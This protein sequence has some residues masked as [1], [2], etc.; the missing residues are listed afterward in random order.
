MRFEMEEENEEY[1]DEPRC[2]SHHP[3]NV[4]CPMCPIHLKLGKFYDVATPEQEEGFIALQL[5]GKQAMACRSDIYARVS[6]SRPIMKEM[7]DFVNGVLE[8]YLYFVP[9]ED[10]AEVEITPPPTTDEK[11]KNKKKKKK[12]K[13]KKNYNTQCSCAFLG[14]TMGEG[15]YDMLCNNCPPERRNKVYQFWETKE[16]EEDGDAKW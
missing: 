9:N 3:Q 10:V 15:E 11:K 14:T 13:K 12:N 5:K 4:L 2:P 1:D 16:K 8:P 6:A 7:N